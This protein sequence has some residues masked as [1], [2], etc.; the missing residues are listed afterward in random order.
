MIVEIN[1]KDFKS[2]DKTVRENWPLY[3]IWRHNKNIVFEAW[4]CDT[5][6]EVDQK[7]NELTGK[8]GCVVVCQ[9]RPRQ[10]SSTPN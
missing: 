3:V 10:S 5:K 9:Y 1:T 4:G 6:E 2:A 8:E 7:W